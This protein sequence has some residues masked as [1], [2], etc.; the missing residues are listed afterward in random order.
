MLGNKGIDFES[1]KKSNLVH[2]TKYFNGLAFDGITTTLKIFFVYSF[3]QSF[4]V[5]I[6][7]KIN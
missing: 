4:A 6:D 7:K 3:P 5:S 2:F 1:V